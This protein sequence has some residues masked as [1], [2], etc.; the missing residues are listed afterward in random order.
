MTAVPNVVLLVAARTATLLNELESKLAQEFGAYEVSIAPVT[1]R[2]YGEDVCRLV[3]GDGDWWDCE[4]EV[5]P[6]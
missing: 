3:P 2:L 5:T 4:F 1:L 6:S